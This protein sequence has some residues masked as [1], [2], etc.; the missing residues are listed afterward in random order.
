MKK[1]LVTLI[2]ILLVSANIL[3]DEDKDESDT[4]SILEEINEK[5]DEI[6]SDKAEEST[7]DY[8]FGGG[9][10]LLPDCCRTCIR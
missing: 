8:G 2:M 5:L 4:I 6:I 1:A 10:F 9:P 7:P 3:A